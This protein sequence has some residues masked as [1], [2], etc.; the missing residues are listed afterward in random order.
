M[1][2]ATIRGIVG[3]LQ[4]EMTGSVKKCLTRGKES[5][6][7]RRTGIVP[8]DSSFHKRFH[9]LSHRELLLGTEVMRSFLFVDNTESIAPRI[10]VFVSQNFITTDI[11]VSF[12]FGFL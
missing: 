6:I 12:D 5:N 8:S 3:I 9:P 11:N 1:V 4:E 10:D 2:W 7:E